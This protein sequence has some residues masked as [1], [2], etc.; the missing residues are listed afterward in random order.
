MDKKKIKP[1]LDDYH[2]ILSDWDIIYDDALAR[3]NGPV[4]QVI[5]LCS[6]TSEVSY[7]IFFYISVLTA[8]GV[9]SPLLC[10][11]IFPLIKLENH[12]RMFKKIVPKIHKLFP[13]VNKPLSPELVLKKIEKIYGGIFRKKI[14]T[15]S[16]PYGLAAYNAYLGNEDRALYWINIFIKKMQKRYTNMEKCPDEVFKCVDFME[17]LQQWIFNNEAY[18]QL[19]RIRIENLKRIIASKPR[20]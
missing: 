8:P 10:L 5:W 18:E 20:L 13:S 12:N 7:E 3:Y 1:F 17:S 9:M 19:E 11:E 14:R 16:I 4:M 15:P 6:K 2:A